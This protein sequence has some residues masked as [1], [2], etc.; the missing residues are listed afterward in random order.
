M[1]DISTLVTDDGINMGQVKAV[2]SHNMAAFDLILEVRDVEQLTRVLTRL[3]ALPNV[4]QVHRVRP[5]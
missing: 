4:M 2:V 3:E 1:R 5:G